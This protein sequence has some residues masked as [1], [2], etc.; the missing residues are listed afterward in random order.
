MKIYHG[1]IDIV[2]KPEIRISE[3]RTL[4]MDTVSTQQH[5]ILNPRIG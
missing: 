5:R 2:E 4:I 1:S 3:H